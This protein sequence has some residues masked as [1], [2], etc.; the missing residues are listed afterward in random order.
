VNVGFS[1]VRDRLQRYLQAR[2]GLALALRPLSEVAA[3][4]GLAPGARV[5]SDGHA[6]Y[7]PVEIGRFARRQD[8]LRLVR[9]SGCLLSRV[10]HRR[11]RLRRPWNAAVLHGWRCP[12]MGRRAI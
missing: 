3:A 6:I 8:N 11:F 12:R 9:W 2:T 10:Q 1:Q 5:C 7:L 4:P